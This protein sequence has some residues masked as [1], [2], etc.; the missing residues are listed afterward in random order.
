MWQ[1]K[2]DIFMSKQHLQIHKARFEVD[3]R[4]KGDSIFKKQRT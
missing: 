4:E 2:D 1:A 3:K